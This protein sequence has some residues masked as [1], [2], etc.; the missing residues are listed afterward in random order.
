MNHEEFEIKVKKMREFQKKYFRTRNTNDL[1]EAKRLEREV[2]EYL[3]GREPE[4]FQ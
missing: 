1:A 4:L 3:A 2:D